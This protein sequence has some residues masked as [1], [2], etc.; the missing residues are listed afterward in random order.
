M[1][2]ILTEVLKS[3]CHGGAKKHQKP[4]RDIVAIAELTKKR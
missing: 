3:S 1:Q 2:M 4:E